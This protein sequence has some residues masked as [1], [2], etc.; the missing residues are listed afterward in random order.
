MTV[1]IDTTAEN[2]GV[3]FVVQGAH[4]SSPSTGHVLLYYVTGTASPGMFVEDSGGN[5]YG[6]FIT[7]SSGGGV[8]PTSS[9]QRYTGGNI[10]LNSSSW[11]SVS[12]PSDLVIAAAAGDILMVGIS[13]L[14]GTENVEGYLDFA[15][16]VS[17]NPVNYVSGGAGGASNRGVVG[18]QSP[19]TTTNIN[20][21]S[22]G[23]IPYVVQSGD[24][25]GGNITLRF[26]YRTSSASNKTLFATADIPLHLFVVNLKH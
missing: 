18:W 24:L 22:Q 9:V 23:S 15:S 2:N 14:W 25:S 16:I 7:G 8:N 19:G 26:R 17:G 13:A 21:G 12:G 11:A 3:R 5:K 20:L 6:P 1:Q 10:T 4:P